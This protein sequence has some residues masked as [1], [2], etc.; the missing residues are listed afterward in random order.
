M[1]KK[2]TKDFVCELFFSFRK[3]DSRWTEL[4]SLGPLI[5]YG[6]A[7]RLGE[8]VGIEWKLLRGQLIFLLLLSANRIFILKSQIICRYKYLNPFCITNLVMRHCLPLPKSRMTH[9][10]PNTLEIIKMRN[11]PAN[12]NKTD[13]NHWTF[14]KNADPFYNIIMEG[15]KGEVDGE[16]FWDAVAEDAVFEFLYDFP[17]F[18][19]EIRGRNNYMDWFGNY[20]YQLHSADNLSIHHS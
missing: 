13:R 6:A 18:T 1:S 3:S 5:N 20:N 9:Q 4:K 16:H 15:L 10:Q 14:N 12:K 17:G 19:N 8:S 7:H 2:E 11:R